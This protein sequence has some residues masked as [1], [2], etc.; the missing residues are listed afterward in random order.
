[1]K[2]VNFA[3]LCFRYV[4]SESSFSSFRFLFSYSSLALFS[5]WFSRAVRFSFCSER[6]ALSASRFW[7]ELRM[8][9]SFGLFS[10]FSVTLAILVHLLF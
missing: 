2:I 10:F 1:M 7:I 5:S 9:S 3:H 8:S 6:R 4:T